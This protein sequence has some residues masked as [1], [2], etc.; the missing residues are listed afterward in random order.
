MKHKPYP[1]YKT[2]GVKW[3]NEVPDHWEIKRLKYNFLLLTN[4]IESP[5]NPIA[6]ENI[7]SW[8]GRFLET[9]TEFNGDGV[10]FVK[11]DILFGKLRPY[12]AK[13]LKAINSGEAVGDFFV[14]RPKKTIG[15]EF[16]AYYLRSENFINVITGATFGSKM[17]R[18]SWEF[19]ADLSTPLPPLPEQQNIAAYLD[20]E[21]AKIDA[22]INKVETAIEKLKEYRTSLISATV[23]GKIDVREQN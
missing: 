2:N 10:A 8:T 13:V 1:K 17:P 7:E 14:L 11:D 3:L 4:K 16:A 22:L 18:V 21:T 12:L 6:L 15:P 9:E 5:K 23:T 20:R 19:M